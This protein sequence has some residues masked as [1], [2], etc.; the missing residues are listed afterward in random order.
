[1]RFLLLLLLLPLAACQTDQTG[2]PEAAPV[3]YE[4]VG[5]AVDRNGAVPVAAVLSEP[6]TYVGQRVTVEGEATEVCTSMGCWAVMRTELADGTPGHIRLN[7]PK[8]AEGAYL[9]TLPTDLAGERIV[10]SGMLSEAVLSEADARH[11]AEDAGKDPSAISGDTS[12]LHLTMTGA[13]LEG[14]PVV[15][16]ADADAPT[17]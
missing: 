8:D 15:D 6:D 14:R 11:L 10:V 17:S 1:M 16:V 2:L 9:W 3:T 12:E 5:D 13:T 7:V 4:Q